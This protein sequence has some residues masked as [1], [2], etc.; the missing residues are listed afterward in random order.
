MEGSPK[1]RDVLQFG[2]IMSNVFNCGNDQ[3]NCNQK[4]KNLLTSCTQ[5]SSKNRPNFSEIFLMLTDIYNNL[6]SVKG[7]KILYKMNGN[8]TSKNIII[9]LQFN[10]IIYV[11]LPENQKNYIFIRFNNNVTFK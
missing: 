2:T 7:K 11:T 4:I 1:K 5:E 3:V 10:Y 8:V 9:N 6:S